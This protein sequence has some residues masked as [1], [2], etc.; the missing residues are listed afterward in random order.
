MNDKSSKGDA[1]KHLR[2]NLTRV[3]AIRAE[4]DAQPVRAERRKQLKSWQVQ[5]LSR[6]YADLLAHP[7]YGAAAEFFRSD[8][9]GPKDFTQR[10]RDVSRVY[11]VMVRLLPAGALAT[12][13][14]ALELDALSEELD[15]DLAIILWDELHCDGRIDENLYAEGYR[16]TGKRAL[17]ERQIE[18]IGEVGRDLDR[19]VH[20]PL[21][22]SSLKMMRR[23]AK[24]AGLAELHHFLERGF[25][26]FRDM[27][28][29]AEFLV[30][31]L[32][33]EAEVL[34]RIFA[35]LPNPFDL[36]T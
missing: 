24:L 32:R 33:R 7:R 25:T 21:L 36:T 20:T 35:G 31:I 3:Q 9:Y 28:G 6:T 10:D 30:I 8:L 4:A 29:A 19:L 22:Y 14:N 17:R 1:A 11:P 5:R 18:V 13:A 16:R 27:N 15:R 23:P 2:E 26:A 12:V 34:E